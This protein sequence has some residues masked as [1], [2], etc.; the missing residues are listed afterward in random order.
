M[1]R[2]SCEC[3]NK[4]MHF[5][6]Y[7]QINFIGI[8]RTNGRFGEVTLKQCRLC[9]RYWLHYHVEYEGFTKSGRFFMG[10]ITKEDANK[11][12]PEDAIPYLEQLDWYLYGG[13]YFNGKHGRS[14]GEIHGD[15]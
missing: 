8:D 1:C 2:P 14:S 3:L 15:L 9:G 12:S 10:V 4:P 13:S 5:D 7:E 6:Q 11:L